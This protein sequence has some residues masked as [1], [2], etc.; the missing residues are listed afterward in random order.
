MKDISGKK[1]FIG[2]KVFCV[3]P[4]LKTS[5]K[6]EITEIRGVDILIAYRGG[7]ITV[8]ECRKLKEL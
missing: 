6:G 2:D 4:Y 8:T 7:I 3:H 1:L 5:I